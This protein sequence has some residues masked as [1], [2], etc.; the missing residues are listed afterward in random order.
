MPDEMYGILIDVVESVA[1]PTRILRQC[2]GYRAIGK[3]LCGPVG[4][5]REAIAQHAQF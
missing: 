2:T 3:C 4:S 1:K 5:L